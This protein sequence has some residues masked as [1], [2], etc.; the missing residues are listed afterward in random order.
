MEGQLPS[1][2]PADLYRHT[3]G[4]FQ[5]RLHL[6]RQCRTPLALGRGSKGT[7]L[8]VHLLDL[9]PLEV[10][11]KEATVQVGDTENLVLTSIVTVS[12]DHGVLLG[13]G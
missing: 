3:P 7:S 13:S 10:L 12:V 4:R 9:V 1:G 5:P 2:L 6:C 11:V 8:D